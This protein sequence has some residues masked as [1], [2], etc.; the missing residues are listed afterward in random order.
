MFGQRRG[1]RRSG[2]AR[3]LRGGRVR[4]GGNPPVPQEYAQALGRQHYWNWTCGSPLE[5][6]LAQP[7][8]GC[9]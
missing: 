5:K 1:A 2:C 9:A 4:L 3:R 7:L 6:R 8:P